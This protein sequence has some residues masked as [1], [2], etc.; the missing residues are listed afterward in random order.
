MSVQMKGSGD[1]CGGRRRILAA[2]LDFAAA[3]RHQGH[4][5]WSRLVPYQSAGQGRET[6][7]TATLGPS[8]GSH[9]G[10]RGVWTPRV[11]SQKGLQTLDAERPVDWQA[12]ESVLN[13]LSVN[14]Y[15]QRLSFQRS[16]P[17]AAARSAGQ[18]SVDGLSGVCGVRRP[19]DLEPDRRGTCRWGRVPSYSSAA[20]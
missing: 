20:G 18:T 1:V 9:R 16:A 12:T 17:F 2:G 5:V 3:M 8:G 4:Q 13:W 11:P 15:E 6:V 19:A 7:R 10:A 14:G